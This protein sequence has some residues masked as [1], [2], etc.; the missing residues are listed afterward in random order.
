MAQ[1][2]SRSL[3]ERV[4]FL[5]L[6][7]PSRRET[8]TGL[9]LGGGSSVVFIGLALALISAACASAP[10]SPEP[11]AIPSPQPSLPQP[12][13]T[14]GPVFP[15]PAAMLLFN[16]SGRALELV[17][18]DGVQLADMGSIVWPDPDRRRGVVLGSLSGVLGRVRFA[19]LT[20]NATGVDL[21]VRSAIGTITLRDFPS[22]AI[23][24]GSVPAGL[25]VVSVPDETESP[26]LTGS[27]LYVIDPARRAGVGEPI[28]EGLE[29]DVV[30]LRLQVEEGQPTG[31]LYC[32][33]DPE[34]STNE[35]G[36]CRGL[37]RV[38]L[39]SGEVEE[40]IPSD[41]G[42]LAI[43]PDMR[44]T[45]LASTDRIPPDV[46]VRNLETGAEVVFRSEAGVREVR[47]GALSPSGARLAWVSLSLDQNGEQIPAL[48]LAS[49]SGGPVTQL[50]NASISEAVGA[51]I[52]QVRPV[53]W[54]DE[55]RLLLEL[56]SSQGSA[57]YVLRMEEGRMDHVAAGRLAGFVYR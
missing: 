6:P 12:S 41:L 44:V 46:R 50:A 31:V 11:T 52:E 10:P 2:G 39:V 22:E 16:P 15:Y 45:A 48:S 17:G 40:I 13:P 47:P 8:K 29:P 49:S 28:V 24:A 3:G 51:P 36:S 33:G 34:L 25:L 53:G 35:V 21:K 19:Y 57:L 20:P 32:V 7:C 4:R 55:G 9:A 56:T 18:Q 1:P 14:A 42:L 38:E 54:L 37:Y 26:G 43:S 30:P 27:V 5:A 23:M